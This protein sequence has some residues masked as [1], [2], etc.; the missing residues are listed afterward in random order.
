MITAPI[1]QSAA[2]VVR[3]NPDESC[4]R[5]DI[6]RANVPTV[7]AI[8]SGSF[9]NSGIMLPTTDAAIAE[10]RIRVNGRRMAISIY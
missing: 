4:P 1:P 10:Q 2:S 7:T 3:L 5:R 9:A 8:S 6:S